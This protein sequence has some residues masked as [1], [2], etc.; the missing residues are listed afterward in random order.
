[1]KQLEEWQPEDLE[2]LNAHDL[3]VDS[4]S[5]NGWSVQEMF[6]KN[7]KFGYKTSY[8]PNMAAYTVQLN[9]DKMDSQE[10]RYSPCER[11]RG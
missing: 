2:G 5:A 3:E 6:A 10:Y 11:W 9:K 1:M 7:E 4:Q 8:D